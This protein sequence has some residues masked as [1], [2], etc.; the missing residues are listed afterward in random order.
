MMVRFYSKEEIEQDDD[1][2]ESS[3]VYG[4][5][6]LDWLSYLVYGMICFE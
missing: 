3:N 1:D 2:H 4:K 6:I 5:K